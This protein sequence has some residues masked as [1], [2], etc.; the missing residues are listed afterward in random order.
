MTKV[1]VTFIWL[2]LFSIGMFGVDKTPECIETLKDYLGKEICI[3]KTID[4]IVIT[5][6]GGASQEIALFK[7]ADKI[8][9]HPSVNHFHQF[10]KMYPYLKDVQNVGSF[11][12]VNIEALIKVNP[13]IVFV[14]ATS[15]HT[16]ESISAIGFPVYTLGIGRHDIASLLEELLH[17]G[18]IFHAEQKAQ[19]VVDYWHKSLMMIEQRIRAVE[20]KDK[21]RVL[22]GASSGKSGM[23]SKRNWNDEFIES[24]GGIN[25]TTD[26]PLKGDVSLESLIVWN[27]D[28]IVTTRS[29]SNK[30]SAESIRQTLALQ[31]VKAI[32]NHQVY[33]G[34]VGTS[35]WDRPSPESILGIIWLAKIL[36]PTQMAD[37]DLK[38]ET[39]YF[40]WTFYNYRLSD[41]EYVNFFEKVR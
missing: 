6:Y 29:T 36:Y 41:D 17:L 11:S 12:N 18:K 15:L 9:A 25:V 40:Y 38:Q 14:G 21:K 8:V 24:A 23:S 7:E 39:L 30:N 28:A 1:Y 27:P 13:S 32:Q 16:N 26:V 33:E 5:C 10:L 35:W 3:P 22:Y 20:S 4:T 2:H 37:I 19:D 34:P 31:H